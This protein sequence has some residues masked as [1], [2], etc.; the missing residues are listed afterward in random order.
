MALGRQCID[1]EPELGGMSRPP[2]VNIS[3]RMNVKIV[4]MSVRSSPK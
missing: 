4:F 3:E 2:K 1:V